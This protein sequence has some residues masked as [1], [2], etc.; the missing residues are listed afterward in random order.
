MVAIIIF[1]SVRVHANLADQ[2]FDAREL[3]FGAQKGEQVQ[4]QV[5]SVNIFVEIEQVSFDGEQVR[6]GRCRLRSDVHDGTV[7]APIRES[8]ARDIHAAFRQEL[9][10]FHLHVC[11]RESDGVTE[12]LADDDRSGQTIRT[13]QIRLCAVHIAVQ[14]RIAHGRG[15]HAFA[16]VQDHRKHLRRE[17]R[18]RGGNRFVIALAASTKAMVVPKEHRN[19][20]A[21]LETKK[22]IANMTVSAGETWLADMD[23]KQLGEVF[24]L[25]NTLV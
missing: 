24:G 17:F 20:F 4:R 21:L 7:N 16:L 6:S 18:E 11:G 10:L 15:T 1:G 3:L 8:C 22:S 2:I 25:D 19:D 23:D 5:L 12:A 14:E 13:A 9:V